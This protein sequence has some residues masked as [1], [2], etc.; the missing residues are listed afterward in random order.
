LLPL[1]VRQWPQAGAREH[2]LVSN[3]FC[4]PYV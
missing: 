2:H 4:Q 3:G 1:H